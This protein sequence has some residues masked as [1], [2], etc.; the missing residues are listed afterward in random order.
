MMIVPA[1]PQK[2]VQVDDLEIGKEYWTPSGMGGVWTLKYLGTEGDGRHTF[3]D[4][5]EEYRDDS[6]MKLTAKR[7]PEMVFV[8]YD[9]MT[10]DEY[11]AAGGTYHD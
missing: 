7:V 1:P 4:R 9:D 6:I 10:A 11:E 2:P 8:R 3:I 5:S